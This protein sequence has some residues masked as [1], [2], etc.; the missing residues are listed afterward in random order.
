MLI[1]PNLSTA[2]INKAL[3]ENRYVEFETGVYDLTKPLIVYSNTDIV[4]QPG[5][6]FKRRHKG[7]MMQL[8]VTPD[9]KAYNGTHDVTWTG[10]TFVADT[11]SANANVITL[12]H[13]KNIRF[14]DLHISGCRGLHSIEVNACRNV[15]I[16]NCFIAEQTSKDKDTFREA[17]Q[18]DFANK[19][20][21][22]ISG[23]DG[24]SPCYDGTHCRN[25]TIHNCTF[26]NCPNGI[27][28][29]TVSEKE[30]YHTNIMIKDCKFDEVHFKDIQLCGVD[31]CTID[32]DAIDSSAYVW[33]L[34]KNV[35]HLNSGGKKKLEEPRRN[36]AVH[37]YGHDITVHIE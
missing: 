32:S 9:T 33:L 2:K 3:K 25:I 23:A 15:V 29:H 5:V 19:D 21:L 11:N 7:R 24:N 18:I 37:V 34:A 10:G 36:K 4:C 8:Y 35:C 13:G 12:F 27:G 28:T 14:K 16:D 22:S 31:V 17:I 30:K 1:T 26:F 20:G 6:V